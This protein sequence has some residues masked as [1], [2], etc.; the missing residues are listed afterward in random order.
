MSYPTLMP[1]VVLA[2]KIC[3]AIVDGRIEALAE[4]SGSRC[5]VS[6]TVRAIPVEEYYQPQFAQSYFALTKVALSDS[7]EPVFDREQVSGHCEAVVDVFIRA[8]YEI[9]FRPAEKRSPGDRSSFMKRHAVHTLLSHLG[10]SPITGCNVSLADLSRFEWRDAK[11]LKAVA[12]RERFR[13]WLQELKEM[14]PRRRRRTYNE[15]SD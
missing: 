11:E 5:L 6:I 9:P 13:Y 2:R 7:V 3:D 4:R 8:V 1:G 15:Y 12:R 14:V 10:R